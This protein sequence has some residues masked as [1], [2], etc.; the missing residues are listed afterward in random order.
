M[1][2]ATIKLKVT[3]DAAQLG[4]DL[5]KAAAQIKP[6]QEVLER[7]K[8]L[9]AEQHAE[10]GRLATSL[11]EVAS[12][13]RELDGKRGQEKEL[14][15]AVREAKMLGAGYK[16]IQAEIATT[17]A[18]AAKLRKELRA[19]T[20]QALATSEEK[21]RAAREKDILLVKDLK[22]AEAARNKVLAEKRAELAAARMETDK[23]AAMAANR[24]AAEERAKKSAI[25]SVIAEERKKQAVLRT[26]EAIRR[27]TEA[28][29]ASAKSIAATDATNRTLAIKTAVGA[30]TTTLAGLG[31]IAR[32][33]FSGLGKVLS[34]L[35]GVIA[36]T[37]RGVGRLVS[38]FAL[39]ARKML[40]VTPVFSAFRAHLR[41]AVSSIGLFNAGVRQGSARLKL[42]YRRLL[43]LTL[44][45]AVFIALRRALQRLMEDMA[46]LM[47]HNEALVKSFNN[48]RVAMWVSF[49]PAWIAVTPLIERFT[50]A[51]AR[52]TTK[53]S[54][55]SALMGGLAW[56]EARDLGEALYRQA[57]GLDDVSSSAR[58]ARRSLLGFDEIFR[59]TSAEA[60]AEEPATLD[61]DIEPPDQTLIDKVQT[62]IDFLRDIMGQIRALG[63]PDFDPKY[64]LSL[65]EQIADA[66]A[67]ALERIPWERVNA[68]FTDAMTAFANLLNGI[69]GSDNF[70]RVSG[71]TL[72][73][74]LRTLLEGI[75]EL[76]RT[77]RFFDFGVR[78]AEIFNRLIALLPLLGETLYL[79]LSSTLDTIDG[80]LS[81]AHFY[82][83]GEGL[84]SM[85]SD[86][87]RIL[88][89][90]G[91]TL[92]ASVNSIFQILDGLFTDINWEAAGASISDGISNLILDVEWEENA[93]ILADGINGLIITIHT[94]LTETPW[95]EFGGVM[96]SGFMTIIESIDWDALG[97]TLGELWNTVIGFLRGAIDE[98]DPAEIGRSIGSFI[99][100]TFSR[101]DWAE[102]GRTISDVVLG[103]LEMILVA[104]Q[105]TDWQLVGKSIATFLSEIDWRE[106]FETAFRAIR[107]AAGGIFDVLS[108]VF[109]EDM[110]KKL[111]VLVP[112]LFGISKALGPVIEGFSELLGAGLLSKAGLGA[113]TAA[114]AKLLLPFAK[115]IAI[116]ATVAGVLVYLWK[117][118]EGFR[119]RVT[120]A[121]ERLKD[122]GE[123][124]WGAIKDIFEALAPIIEP[125]VDILASLLGLAATTGLT[126][127]V[128]AVEKIAALFEFVAALLSGDWRGMLDALSKF[129][130][131]IP[132]VVMDIAGDVFDVGVEIIG[133]LLAGMAE[134][135]RDIYRW[136]RDNIFLPIRAGL[137]SLF[138]IRSPSTKMLEIGTSIITGLLDG[139]LGG[140]GRV[141]DAMAEVWK[142]ITSVFSDSVAWLREQGTKMV[143]GIRDGATKARDRA[144]GAMVA[145]RDGI[146]EVFSASA[147]WFG[148]R[149]KEM[150]EGL[151]GAM[152]GAREGAVS[153]GRTI[154]NAIEEDGFRGAATLLVSAGRSIA[155]GLARGISGA[156]ETATRAVRNLGRSVVDS[157]KSVLRASSPSLVFR[158]EVGAS[159]PEGIAVGIK[160]TTSL[161]VSAI[162]AALLDVYDEAGGASGGFDG[163][164]GVI[165]EK[166][167]RGIEAMSPTAVSALETLYGQMITH[168]GKFAEKMT[169]SIQLLTAEI[170]ELFGGLGDALPAANAAVIATTANISRQ[171]ILAHRDTE[172][173]KTGKSFVVLNDSL[174]QTIPAI[175]SFKMALAKVTE[176]MSN[177][178]GAAT[179]SSAVETGAK[180]R[181]GVPTVITAKLGAEDI[182]AITAGFI[183]AAEIIASAIPTEVK[184][185]GSMAELM[186]ILSPRLISSIN[187]ISSQAGRS[188]L[189]V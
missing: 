40:L 155:E 156:A 45:W 67:K 99:N 145:V 150:V 132:G 183:A 134:S 13:I 19:T 29:R 1:A 129:F 124:I 51:I 74:G 60:Q 66:I 69:L 181:N 148:T 131:V 93:A 77:F 119:E 170:K 58:A 179:I 104:I 36:S 9:L 81:E 97:E 70:W 189:R 143:N 61:F 109:G 118:N 153:A 112:V 68:V 128:G 25:D 11:A 130:G 72:Y 139:V 111:M 4:V 31:K 37:V 167:A 89:R 188:P 27:K 22:A 142:G 113:V 140:V 187:D 117:T 94:A 96:M 12:R 172:V 126:V 53:L 6:L 174:A 59:L 62:L 123:T 56:S 26:E 144:I 41:G 85:F 2:D 88:P 103:L 173:G 115:I 169:A 42:L 47:R 39:L 14:E 49:A 38:S 116:I 91:A 3:A 180:A 107:E 24:A 57:R 175:N 43:R 147:A 50:A 34:G 125:V 114:A 48:V 122:A 133:G 102:T 87:I 5:R 159:I 79:I 108:E 110:A 82:R 73:H 177:P 151:S 160:N 10:A 158:D 178:F 182:A 65:G 18:W 46:G 157:A 162:K 136:V 21:G 7:T 20:T 137:R 121:W 35:Y 185:T 54:V 92:G 166:L 28:E 168:T 84:A 164:G 16:N 152:S 146:T 101:I 15:L 76:L 149:G 80:I 120:S 135:M 17:T 154:M 105:E 100:S 186:R 33:V 184:T 165:V 52:A 75:N 44:G 176:T 106:I 86:V 98:F 161:M 171:R 71:D 95:G 127:L 90:L 64:W 138:G 163:Y 30:L 32:A 63:T 55:F 141:I 83:F 8:R 23:G 78:I